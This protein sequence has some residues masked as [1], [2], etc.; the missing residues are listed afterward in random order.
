M[1][2]YKFIEKIYDDKIEIIN[3]HSLESK[4]SDTINLLDNFIEKLSDLSCSLLLITQHSNFYSSQ[5]LSRVIFEHFLVVSYVWNRARIEES[6]TCANEYNFGY[7]SYEVFKQTNYNS[8]LERKNEKAKSQLQKILE[9]EIF[10]ELNNPK[11]SMSQTNLDEI[12]KI[13]N[14]FDVRNILKYFEGLPED[15]PY[16][17]FTA[18][19]MDACIRYNNLSSY[20]HGGRLAELEALDDIPL[21]DKSKLMKEAFGFSELFKCIVK[22]YKMILLYLEFDSFSEVY[23]LIIKDKELGIIKKLNKK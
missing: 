15:E 5:A 2:H 16:K 13:G 8:M 22:D 12:N 20:I 18:I 6:N 17:V 1:E 23:N 11:D 14:Q 7:L 9:T 21:I 3:A 19:A 10:S 4:Y